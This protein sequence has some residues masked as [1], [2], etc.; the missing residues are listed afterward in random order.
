MCALVAT[1]TCELVAKRNHVA[2][3][4]WLLDHG[5]NPNTR[6]AHWDAEV[7]PLHLAVL[8]DHA[9][10]VRLLLKAGAD[11]RIR[12]SKHHSDALGWAEHIG[13]RDSAKILEAHT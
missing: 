9:E 7:T 11:P 8:H 2:A 1:R 12:D 6:W 10:I 4:K 13:R 3:V 5:A